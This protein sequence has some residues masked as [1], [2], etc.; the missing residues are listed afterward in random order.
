[1]QM[2]IRPFAL[3]FSSLA[4][5]SGLTFE[6]WE[7]GLLAYSTRKHELQP[8]SSGE[9]GTFS[10]LIND[11]HAF[12]TITATD[13]HIMS[14][15]PIRV[16]DKSGGVL[17][18]HDQNSQQ[19]SLFRNSP[20]PHSVKM[21]K[22][23]TCLAGIMEERW[24][25]QRES[26]KMVEELT[27]HL[28]DLYLYSR[29]STQV[30]TLTFSG[31]MLKN[32]IDELL[33]SMR[34]DI[35]FSIFPERE[36]YNCITCRE[37]PAVQ[38]ISPPVFAKALIS[39]IPTNASSLQDDYFIINDS[40]LNPEYRRLHPDP[41]RFLAAAIRDDQTFFGWVCLV[42]FNMKEIFRQGELR[43]LKSLAKSTTVS[44]EN[45]R[46]YRESLQM[47]EK[48]RSIR[49][50]FQKYVPAEVADEILDRGERE[51]IQLGEKRRVS[52]LN[53]DIRGYSKMSKSLRAEDVVTILNHFFMIMGDA[54]INHRGILDKYLGDGILAIFGAPVPTDNPALDATLAA[55]DMIKNLD[56]VTEFTMKKF[57]I[58]I[59]IGISINT[60]EV[61]LGNIG[62]DRKMEYTVIGDAV[63]DTFRI[64]EM[65][66]K[67]PNSI[68]ISKNTQEE[69]KPHIRTRKLRFSSRKTSESKV[70]VYKV[71]GKR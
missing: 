36:E 4:E 22:F 8:E 19:T 21:E 35:A 51:L 68:L 26:V 7:K 53:V 28:G 43:L 39:M 32:L 1:M 23:L 50:I 44:L 2:D 65:T 71:T 52:L 11:A 66:R 60:G 48:E 58:P 46:L 59:H 20:E 9:T 16:N 14:G 49:N 33:E 18:V 5:V 62:F 6:V 10:A 57:G 42:S 55:I 30:K 25:F 38:K 69:I 27:Q 17:I 29:I 31:D 54:I 15:V 3:L 24:N 56:E 41:F 64:Q 67:L 45:A 40:Q 61:I 34:I 13:G 37:M 47:A 70:E 12:S 63:N